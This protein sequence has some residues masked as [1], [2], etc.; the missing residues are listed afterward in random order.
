MKD[1]SGVPNKLTR[2]EQFALAREMTLRK[3]AKEQQAL[4]EHIA[5]IERDAD[6]CTLY[7]TFTGVVSK[8]HSDLIVSTVLC[9]HSKDYVAHAQWTTTGKLLVRLKT[10]ARLF[11]SDSRR[12]AR[13][14]IGIIASQIFA[15]FK[16]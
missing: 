10:P 14:D 4:P 11:N 3:R 15:R 9:E 8:L 6:N 16:P 5:A 12:A 1:E 2:E 13:C 7:I